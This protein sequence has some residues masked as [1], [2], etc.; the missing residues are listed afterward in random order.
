M[1]LNESGDIP[2]FCQKFL[3]VL[4]FFPIKWIVISKRAASGPLPQAI[5]GVFFQRLFWFNYISQAFRHF[6]AIGTCDHPIY[7]QALEAGLSRQNQISEYCIKCPC[8]YYLIA[9]RPQ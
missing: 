1:H 5:S 4:T 7:H 9:L 3:R 2:E 8:P 6:S